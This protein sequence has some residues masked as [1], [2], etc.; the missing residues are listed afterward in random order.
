MRFLKWLSKLLAPAGPEKPIAT[1]SDKPLED[2]DELWLPFSGF[3]SLWIVP[4]AETKLSMDGSKFHFDH[5]KSTSLVDL[6]KVISKCD[7]LQFSG[8]TSAILLKQIRSL[9]V[10]TPTASSTP[11]ALKLRSK[12][13]FA[14]VFDHGIASAAAERL[15]HVP[16]ENL[17]MTESEKL[18]LGGVD[19][20][21]THF[22]RLARWFSLIQPGS[23]GIWL[24][25]CLRGITVES[26][27]EQHS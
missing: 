4:D 26:L 22:D 18:F 12:D 5:R 9:G 19:T 27:V 1:T 6:L 21:E 17:A 11:L 24:N 13:C 20:F 8:F 16:D 15:T 14:L 2:D 25:D 3:T 10:N 23:H 7:P